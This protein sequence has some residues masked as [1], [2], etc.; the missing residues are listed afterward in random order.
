MGPAELSENAVL[1]ASGEDS[2]EEVRHLVFRFQRLSSLRSPGTVDFARLQSLE[3]LSL[4]HN[5]LRD[6]QPLSTLT[7]LSEVNLNFNQIQDLSPLFECQQLSKAF[8]A[9]NQVESIAGLE[10]CKQLQELSL[11]A[12]RLTGEAGIGGPL[13]AYAM[14]KHRRR[15]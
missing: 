8:V 15:S 10:S 13:D 6:I 1:V 9:H 3:V 5:Q 4:S 12:N 7:T 2:V 14:N 11:L